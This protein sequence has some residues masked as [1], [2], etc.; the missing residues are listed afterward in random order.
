MLTRVTGALIR[1]SANLKISFE[2]S[3]YEVQSFL[4]FLQARFVKG[5]IEEKKICLS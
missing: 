2:N 1:I 4:L 3:I 5:K